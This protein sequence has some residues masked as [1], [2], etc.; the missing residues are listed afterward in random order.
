[1]DWLFGLCALLC[2]VDG[3]IPAL[4]NLSSLT[5]S[6]IPGD[7]SIKMDGCEGHQNTLETARW[8][9]GSPKTKI[10]S[11]EPRGFRLVFRSSMHENHWQNTS[12]P[13][14]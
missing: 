7:F 13:D 14:T 5:V 12:I 9:S 11:S 8:S 3:Q 1:M 2:I 4:V 6:G 10:E